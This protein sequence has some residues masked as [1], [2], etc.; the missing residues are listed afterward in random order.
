MLIK[1]ALIIS[2]LL[3][4]GASATSIRLIKRT[5][6]NISWILISIGL[7]LMAFRRLYDLIMIYNVNIEQ[8]KGNIISAWVSVL[9]SLLMFIGVIYIRQIFNLQ[10]KIDNL[11]KE[12]ESKVL[13]AIIKAEEETKKKFAKELHD[14]LG[15]V[16]SSIKMTISAINREKIGEKNQQIIDKTSHAIDEA[17]V[18]VKEVSNNLSPHI[19]QNYGLLKAVK[20]FSDNINLDKSCKIKIVSNIE[21]TRLNQDIEIIFYRIICELIINTIKY[22]RAGQIKIGLFLKTDSLHLSYSDNG[23]GFNMED[24][25]NNSEG[26]GLSNI[27]SRIKSLNG[28]LKMFSKPGKGFRLEIAVKI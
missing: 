18:T 7:I 26:M 9:I 2:V 17:L 19:L 22:A 20:T 11:R 27:K 1:V 16:L 10:Q 15:P 28:E 13:A 3:Q 24:V 6:Y 23:K 5:K 14:G 21:Q 12:N 4:F 25:Q 8:T